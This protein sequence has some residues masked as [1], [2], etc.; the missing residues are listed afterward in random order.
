MKITT[1]MAF[2]ILV[3][4]TVQTKQKGLKINLRYTKL[5]TFSEGQVRIAEIQQHSYLI[6]GPR[7]PKKRYYTSAVICAFKHHGQRWCC[8]VLQYPELSKEA[9]GY[10]KIWACSDSH[11]PQHNLSKSHSLVQRSLS[12]LFLFLDTLDQMQY[13][14]RFC[15]GSYESAN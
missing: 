3:L 6:I 12:C 1:F 7:V 13:Y 5:F 15:K 11:D 14:S 10:S 4:P 9:I 2:Y 8:N